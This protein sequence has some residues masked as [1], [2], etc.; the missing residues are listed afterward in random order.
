MQDVVYL[1]AWATARASGMA[2][3]KKILNDRQGHG[4][5]SGFQHGGYPQIAILIGKM[6][7]NSQFLGGFP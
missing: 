4:Q 7:L 5:R 1:Q 3:M 2:E 6:M